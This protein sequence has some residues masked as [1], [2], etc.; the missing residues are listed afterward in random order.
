[1]NA[2]NHKLNS[3]TEHHLRR[4]IEPLANYIN[5]ASRPKTTLRSALAVLLSEIEDTNRA[6]NIYVATFAE[7]N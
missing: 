2:I 1:M 5:A 7:T 3:A 6:A 4:V